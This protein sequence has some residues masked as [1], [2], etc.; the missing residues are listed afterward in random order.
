MLN[1]TPM[2]KPTTPFPHSSP[3][4]RRAIGWEHVNIGDLSQKAGVSY[5]NTCEILRGSIRP[6]VSSAQKLAYALGLTI[7]QFLRKIDR[8]KIA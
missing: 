4:G 3:R 6:S 7:D 5:T 2:R 1:L 8:T